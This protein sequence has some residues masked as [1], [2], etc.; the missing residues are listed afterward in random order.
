[1]FDE[2]L[3]ALSFSSKRPLITLLAVIKVLKIG[4]EKI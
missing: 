1:M 2:I 3:L 4:E